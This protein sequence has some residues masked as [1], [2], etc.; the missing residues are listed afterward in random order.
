[1]GESHCC[2]TSVFKMSVEM[3]L[4]ENICLIHGLAALYSIDPC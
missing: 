3:E 4:E 2:S 1:M